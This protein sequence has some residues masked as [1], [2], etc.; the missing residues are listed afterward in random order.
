MNNTTAFQTLDELLITL[1]GT[2]STTK[3]CRRYAALSLPLEILHCYVIVLLSFEAD[4]SVDKEAMLLS[5][6]VISGHNDSVVYTV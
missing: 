3:C 2:G 1:F 5:G 6:L 4:S